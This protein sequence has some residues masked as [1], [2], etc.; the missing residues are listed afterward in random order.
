M[1]TEINS[2]EFFRVEKVTRSRFNVFD[3][4]TGEHLCQLTAKEIDG[5]LRRATKALREA[6][7]FYA[8][9]TAARKAKAD[10]IRAERKAKRGLQGG[11]NF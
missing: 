7:V 2:N 9:R 5:W 10:E 4:K 8:E 1:T 6:E 11:F 3:V